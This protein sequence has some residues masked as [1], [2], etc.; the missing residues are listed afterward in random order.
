MLK[1]TITYKD[2]DGNDVTEDFYFSISMAETLGFAADQ[3]YGSYL[4]TIVSSG[5]NNKILSAFTEI[6]GKAVGRRSDDGKRLEKS[7]TVTEEFITSDAYSVLL[8]ELFTKPEY[9]AEFINN[10]FPEDLA[11]KAAEVQQAQGGQ[12]VELPTGQVMTR[13]LDT[14]SHDE[15]VTM[16]KAEFDSLFGTDPKKWPR[17]ALVAAMARKT[18]S[19]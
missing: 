11:R 19:N 1:K 2:L 10:V 6:L 18:T 4:R 9:A 15:L 12:T 8:W 14:Y 3:D 17:V 5:D 7:P 13:E 16:S